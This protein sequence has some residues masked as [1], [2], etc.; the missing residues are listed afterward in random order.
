[1]FHF[2]TTQLPDVVG[3]IAQVPNP[4]GAPPP[5]SD[6]FLKILNW[7]AWI[8]TAAAV[9][10]VFIVGAMM[11]VQHQ[12]GRGGEHGAKLTWVMGGCVLIGSASGIVGALV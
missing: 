7:A 10:G 8:A 1:V 9:A 4:T 3:V 5:G 12:H 6:K 11:A 2:L